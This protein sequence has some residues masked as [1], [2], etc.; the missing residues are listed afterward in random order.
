MAALDSAQGLPDLAAGLGRQGHGFWIF[1][2][3]PLSF[4]PQLALETSTITPQPVEGSVGRGQAQPA[5]SRLVTLG[6]T[7]VEVEEDLLGHVLSRRLFQEHS[8]GD[9]H[10]RGVLGLEQRL[11]ANGPSRA[12]MGFDRPFSH[13]Q[14]LNR[15]ETASSTVHTKVSTTAPRVV[16]FPVAGEPARDGPATHGPR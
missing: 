15:R 2:G 11:E 6:M 14:R 16:T 10:H 13:S 12:G 1:A 9:P 5:G 8:G 3:R 4:G 7:E